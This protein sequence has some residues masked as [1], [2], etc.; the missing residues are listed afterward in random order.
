MRRTLLAV[1]GLAPQV[2]TETL[3]ALHVQGRLPDAVRLLT[4]LEGKLAVNAML[5]GP[6]GQLARFLADYDIPP[7]RLEFG[8]VQAVTDERDRP[9]EDIG[10]AEDNERFLAACLEAAFDLTRDPDG[11]VYFSIAGGRKTMGACLALAAQCY[12]RPQDRLYHVLVSPEFERCRDFFYPPPVSRP[13]TLRDAHGQPYEK[14]TRYARVTLL[15]MPFFSIRDRLPPD[16]LT[17]PASPAALSRSLITDPAGELVVDLPG[18]R[19]TWL[20]REMDLM[21][22]RLALYAFFARLKQEADCQADRCGRCDRCFLA[23]P[24]ILARQADISALHARLQGGKSG[25]ALSD[26]GIQALNQENFNSYRTKLNRDLQE[27]FGQP[28][29]AEL[30][31]VSRGRRPGVRYGLPL[32]RTRIRIIL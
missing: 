27:C 12:G 11:A 7:A 4:T 13:V 9:I 18:K 14:E 28:A 22:A 31:I 2:V 1:C 23:L 15:P 6:D 32:E 16:M 3:Y 19:V 17:A 29:A 24:E 20:G 26:T 21:P 8:P 25:G 10:S 5:A 30:G